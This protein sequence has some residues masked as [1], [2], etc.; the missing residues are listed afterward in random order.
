MNIQEFKNGWFIGN[1]EPSL[2]KADFEVGLRWN[3]V[4]HKVERH[5]HKKNTEYIVFPSGKHLLNGKVYGYGE[6]LITRPYQSCDYECLDPGYCLTVRDKS[7]PDDKVMG[8]ALSVVIPM[9][10]KGQRFKDAGYT[11]PKPLI[12]IYGKPMIERVVDNFKPKEGRTL[13]ISRIDLDIAEVLKLDHET[14]GAVST[15]LEAEHLIGRED[16]MIIANCDQLILNFDLEDFIAKSEDCS[17]VTFECDN[18]HHSYAKVENGLV[19]NVAEKEVISTNAIGG[20][21]YYR[22][23]KYFFDGAKKMIEKNLRVNNEF[24][25]SPVFNEIIAMGHTV[26]IYPIKKEDQQILGTPEELNIFKQKVEGGQ[27]CLS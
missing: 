26:N 16:P 6:M 19:T 12:D 13:L 10:G 20:V 15:V 1:F 4:G 27:I 23:A 9:A 2:L 21:Y 3:E 17:V 7:D 11:V 24:Y 25:V 14:E 18:P 5:Y 8:H 22:K